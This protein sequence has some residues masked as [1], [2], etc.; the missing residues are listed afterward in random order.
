MRFLKLLW[1]CFTVWSVSPTSLKGAEAILVHAAG[2]N[3]PTDPGKVNKYLGQLAD[4]LS[5]AYDLPVFAQGEVAPCLIDGFVAAISPRQA[6]MAPNYLNTWDIA[7]WHKSECDMR[8]ITK[9]ILVSYY[10]HYW[11]AL[12]ATEK[13]ELTVLVPPDLREMYDAR[14]SQVWARYKIINRPYELLA[15]LSFLKAGWI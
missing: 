7:L 10:P 2:E 15:R 13:A 12:K 11:R 5:R 14:N 6:E 9:V 3:S 4:K 8:G 1:E